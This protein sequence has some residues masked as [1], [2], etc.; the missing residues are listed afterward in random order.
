[1]LTGK[2]IQRIQSLYSKGVQSDDSRLTS[3]HIYNKMLTLRSKLLTQKL[4]KGQLV[5]DWN[6]VVL[7][8]VE[9]I[10]VDQHECSCLPQI[11]CKLYRTKNKLPKPLN[12]LSDHHIK[13]VESIEHSVNFNETTR[14][15]ETYNSGNRYTSKEK[16]YLIENEYLYFFGGYPG[17][18]VAIKM[19]AHDPLEA[20]QFEQYC[21]EAE[22]T[23]CFSPLTT[24]FPI[25]D[26]LLDDMITMAVPELIQ[27][28][29]AG[30]EDL[31]N[32]TRDNNVET[33]K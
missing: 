27:A 20:A 15:K 17:K 26:D 18:A 12:D 14:M 11:G 4:K 24:E 13:W 29:G 32:N 7:K 21:D 9:I 31:T 30:Q 22:E 33:S 8:C 1:M 3:R 16:R 6:Y 19:L 25:D 28:F 10:E 2:I 23:E 5:N